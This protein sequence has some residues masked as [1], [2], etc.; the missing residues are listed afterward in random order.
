[1]KSLDL[2]LLLL[3]LTLATCNSFVHIVAVEIQTDGDNHQHQVPKKLLEKTGKGLGPLGSSGSTV[4]SHHYI[5]RNQYDSHTGGATQQ[6]PEG[7]YDNQGNGGGVS[8]NLLV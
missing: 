8:N 2:L 4:D 7:D 6:P 1:M 3:V 5:P